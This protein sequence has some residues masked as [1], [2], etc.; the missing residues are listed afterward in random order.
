MKK[1]TRPK[2]KLGNR[3]VSKTKLKSR[4]EKKKKLVKRD[5]CFWCS[6]ANAA[7]TKQRDDIREARSAFSELLERSNN[8]TIREAFSELWKLRKDKEWEEMKKK[9]G[10]ENGDE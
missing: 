10:I 9:A 1:K 4:V 2:K 8:D 5:D 7:I 6:I 3:G